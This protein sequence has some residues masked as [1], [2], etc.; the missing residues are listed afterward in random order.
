[1]PQMISKEHVIMMPHF[2]Y[3]SKTLFHE[4]DGKRDLARQRK[5]W[6]D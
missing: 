4:R 2:R 5:S 1:M 6:K 3:T